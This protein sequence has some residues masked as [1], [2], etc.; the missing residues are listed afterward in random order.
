LLT[1]IDPYC[2]VV[3]NNYVIPF[4]AKRRHGQVQKSGCVNCNSMDIPFTS[5]GAM[6][7]AHYALVRKVESTTSAQL[8]DQYLLAEIRS[9]RHRLAQPALSLLQ[10]KE[11]LLVL[12]YCSMSVSYS[13][14]A[15]GALDFA[16]SHA[17]SLAEAGQTVQD[18]RIGS[19]IFIVFAM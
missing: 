3:P 13:L 7:R 10:C 12:L 1:L 17:V 15:N 16:L 14:L 18:K 9:I 2:P 19:S 6:S 8:V 11:C 5:S 4:I